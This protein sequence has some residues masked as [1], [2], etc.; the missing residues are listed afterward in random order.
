MTKT[1]ILM[2]HPDFS[3]SRANR[4]LH[5]A[6]ARLPGVEI[7]D[8]A[9]L[10]PDGR[11]D[12]DAEVARL[13]GADRLI[14]QFPIQWYSTP[15]LMKAWQDAVLTRMMY[16]APQTEGAKLA[17]MPLLVVATAG[18]VEESYRPEGANLFPLIE[19]LKPLQA[20]A[21]RCGFVW[22]DPYLVYE[23]NRA[24]ADVL[25]EAGEVYAERIELWR[26]GP[27]LRAA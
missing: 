16:L 26:D 27:A 10:Y 12:T 25:S 17:G 13:L 6:A 11:I 18:N 8:V 19:L 23:A 5:D 20:T 21:H 1:L 22:A 3:A 24:G 2:F 9:E 14:L 4:A 7:V 15:P